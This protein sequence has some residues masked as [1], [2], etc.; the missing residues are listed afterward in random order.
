MIFIPV[1]SV[2][3]DNLAEE[4]L[5]FRL[6]D[7]A[8]TPEGSEMAGSGYQ[9]L[10]HLA[11]AS[12]LNREINLRRLR[13]SDL[14]VAAIPAEYSNKAMA[15]VMLTTLE[16]DE[17]WES[18][19]C[20]VA[21]LPELNVGA[22]PNRVG[23]RLPGAT[24]KSVQV[25]YFI[26]LFETMAQEC[27]NESDIIVEF[28][29]GFGILAL[30][31]LRSF[32]LEDKSA[33]FRG[34][35][36]LYDLPVASAVQEYMLTLA[37]VVVGMDAPPEQQ[38]RVLCVSDIEHLKKALSGAEAYLHR[39]QSVQSNGIASMHSQVTSKSAPL[40]R[41]FI[42]LWSFSESPRPT[43]DQML[44]LLANFDR[45]FV[46]YQPIF[47][48]TNNRDYFEVYFKRELERRD[49]RLSD[50][51]SVIVWSDLA[52]PGVTEAEGSRVLV[53]TRQSAKALP[54][55]PAP[56]AV[57]SQSVNVRCVRDAREDSEQQQG[58]E[59]RH[60]IL[61]ARESIGTYIR[62]NEAILR[63]QYHIDPQ[64]LADTIFEAGT[65]LC[66][67]PRT[68]IDKVEADKESKTWEVAVTF[69]LVSPY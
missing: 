28:G 58:P 54:F 1:M 31:I 20:K 66:H 35:Y 11:L 67:R 69:D 56:T 49:D 30:A 29:G 16:M 10:H 51:H 4:R 23:D 47:E 15:I 12:L 34:I 43:R 21:L 2:A 7:F 61:V 36:I 59:H 3:L 48:S 52:M 19:Y 27:I 44:P 50:K 24:L 64:V 57:L 60:T 22:T 41:T 8:R 17:Q 32:S 53:G 55:R 13:D 62:D 5:Y 45:F 26:A 39:H 33:G 68:T 6:T 63:S 46:G 42:A 37:G 65:K 18:R 9:Q 25:A 40:V 14:I 38:F